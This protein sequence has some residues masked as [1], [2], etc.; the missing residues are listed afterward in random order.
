MSVV[1]LARSG[2]LADFLAG[3]DPSDCNAADPMGRTPLMAAL[4]NP[5]PTARVAIATRLLDDGADPSALTPSGSS[6]LHVLFTQ[7]RHDPKAEAPLL[8]RLL[9]GGADVNATM[10]K[11][12]TPLQCLM[13]LFDYTDAQLSPLYDV[14][15]ERADLQLLER[16]AH[17]NTTLQSA[18]R[19]LP[20]RAELVQRMLAYLRA[21]DIEV[22]EEQP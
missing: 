17:R 19:L 8:R 20:Q 16:A 2:T 4:G 7:P 10:T 18:Q 6:V 22:P 9:E 3:Y 14:L 11:F 5:D 21:H 15:F 13:A 12:G 1:K